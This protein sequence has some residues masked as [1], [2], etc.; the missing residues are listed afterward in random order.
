MAPIITYLLTLAR[1]RLQADDGQTAAEVLGMIVVTAAVIAAIVG[2][3]DAIAE[4]F[5]RLVD[6]LLEGIAGPSE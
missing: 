4:T 5:T 2:Q 1:Q 3:A 6:S